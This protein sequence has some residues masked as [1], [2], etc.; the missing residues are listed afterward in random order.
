MFTSPAL[1]PIPN[2]SFQLSQKPV[3]GFLVYPCVPSTVKYRMS[4]FYNL[5][6]SAPQPTASPLPPRNPCP[7]RSKPPRLPSFPA[8]PAL[9]LDPFSFSFSPLATHHSPLSSLESTLTKVYQNKPFQLPCNHIHTKIGGG[10]GPHP[11]AR[12]FQ[13]TPL[14]ILCTPNPLSFHANTK[15]PSRNPFPLISMQKPGGCLFQA[16]YPVR[17][18]VLRSIA[19]KDL[20]SRHHFHLSPLSSIHCELFSHFS[21]HQNAATPLKSTDSKLFAKQRRVSLFLQAK[22]FS[23]RER[24][25]HHDCAPRASSAGRHTRT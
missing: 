24:R 9:R 7:L 6:S 8:R 25:L 19:T 1:R 4:R 22:I 3:Q 2:L 10:G 20:S 18:F 17:I 21:L 23:L 14:C 5:G 16:K 15:R 11:P 13:C 12:S